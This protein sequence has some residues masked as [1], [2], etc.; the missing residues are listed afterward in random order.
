MIAN[1]YQKDI[2]IT[3]HYCYKVN[4]YKNYYRPFYLLFFPDNSSFF[5][6]HKATFLFDKLFNLNKSNILP[7]LNQK[8][9]DKIFY[10]FK[11]WEQNQ[12]ILPFVYTN[13]VN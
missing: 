5:I 2:G 6:Y 9:M 11:L 10:D 7:C 3:H 4:L 13:R 8:H 12:F 1:L